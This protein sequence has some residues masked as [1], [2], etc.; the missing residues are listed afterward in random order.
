MI[1]AYRAAG[2]LD[3]TL[4]SVLVGQS[5]V[6]D[7]VVVVDDGSADGAPAD[8]TGEIAE[9]WAD[10]GPLRV[11]RQSNA[12]PAA[13]RRAG[14][15]ATTSE[16][17]AFVDAD[18]VWLPDHLAIA[19]TTYE[20]HGGLV[21]PD[22]FT[23]RPGA[24]L[25]IATRRSRFAVPGRGSQRSAILREN[26]VFSSV[27]CSRDDYDA[28]GGYQDGVTGAEDWDLWIRMIEHGVVVH[29]TDVATWWYRVAPDGLTERPDMRATYEEVLHR[30][31]A[32]GLTTEERR[33]ADQ[34]LARLA[35]RRALD[36]A[37]TSARAGRAMESRR[38][39]RAVVAQAADVGAPRVAAE[40]A[41]I[42][43]APR[44]AARLGDAARTRW[45][46]ARR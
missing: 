15:A 38:R 22:A 13:A 45:R 10:R 42:A 19:L 43:C 33:V 2:T 32:R 16:L 9:R 21:S 1:P 46:G 5:R 11:I 14:V 37:Y 39:A 6:P 41:A 25:P 3:T 24:P 26:F 31:I 12:G 17:L 23:W 4:A 28:A 7:E 29:G 20:D 8:T 44:S 36:E 30:A 40:A 18:D 34:H 35:A 27:L